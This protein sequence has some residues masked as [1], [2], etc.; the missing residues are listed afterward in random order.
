V[1]TEGKV[2]L[3]T[4]VHEEYGL[5]AALAVV[6]LPK[7][8]WYYHRKHKVSYEEKYAHIHPLLGK[9][10]PV[11]IHPT[12][13]RASPKSYGRPMLRSSTIRLSTT[14]MTP[15][16]R[17]IWRTCGLTKRHF[18]VGYLFG[19]LAIPLMRHDPSSCA[20]DTNFWVGVVSSL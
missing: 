17:S 7:S 3:V 18:R 10:S 20:L 8:T 5:A 2:E 14:M 19:S 6:E 1:S 16:A 4:S 12:A 9:R 13:S 11:S 15:S